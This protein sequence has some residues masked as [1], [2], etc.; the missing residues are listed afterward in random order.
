MADDAVY[1]TIGAAKMSRSIIVD[2][3]ELERLKEECTV[4]CIFGAHYYYDPD[5]KKIEAGGVDMK[6]DKVSLYVHIPHSTCVKCEHDGYDMKC[7][8][9]GPR[10]SDGTRRTKSYVRNEMIVPF[11]AAPQSS[12]TALCEELQLKFK[13]Q[14]RNYQIEDLKRLLP[15]ID[16]F[17][18]CMFQAECGYGKTVV[19][20]YLIA[21]FKKRAIILT[22]NER[23]AEQNASLIRKA[24]DGCTV[25]MTS[26]DGSFDECAD[27]LVA[28]TSQLKGR[29][30]LFK[31]YK[32]AIFDEIH[33][34]SKP[35]SIAGMLSI[36]PDILIGFTATPQKKEELSRMFT[37]NETVVGSHRMRWSIVYLSVPFTHTAHPKEFTK[38]TTE[39]ASCEAFIE[40]IKNLCVY[41]YSRNKR[42]MILT[43]RNVLRDS[44]SD[45]IEGQ[46]ISVSNIQAGSLA[47]NADV[48]IGNK[49]M[50]GTGFDLGN[51]IAD[52]DGKH[53]EVVIFAF[54]LTDLTL[55]NQSSGRSFRSEYPL[56]IFPE[57]TG[58]STS[59]RHVREHK[60]E[61][62]DNEYCTHRPIQ[63][64]MLQCVADGSLD[65]IN[66]YDD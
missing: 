40:M 4:E 61:L 62:A 11:T 56:V 8:T 41:F 34:L 26:S 32:L 12:T 66:P 45:I 10:C 6:G 55:F 3:S 19:I 43:E 24:I 29:L 63:Q 48:V 60:N 7:T 54:T 33:A 35:L 2:N 13:F 42:V 16:K 27:I 38:I 14:L 47:K 23:C 64:M 1:D 52:F 49:G 28:V 9:C 44:L 57:F 17:G 39:M 51:A 53:P 36:Q 20:A 18:C 37:G 30:G 46:G 58:W 59:R 22:P 50:V 31:E 21:H 15:T 65:P 5:S 25:A